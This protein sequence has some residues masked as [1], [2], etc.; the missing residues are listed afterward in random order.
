MIAVVEY[1]TR[2][3]RPNVRNECLCVEC[4]AIRPILRIPERHVCTGIKPL[5]YAAYALHA[6]AETGKFLVIHEP[7]VEFVA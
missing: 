7:P 4:G 1:R 3:I 5:L 6:K 2:R